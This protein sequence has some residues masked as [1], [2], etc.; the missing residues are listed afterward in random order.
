[1]RRRNNIPTPH[2]LWAIRKFEQMIHTYVEE[3][4]LNMAKGTGHA[5]STAYFERHHRSDGA[6][7][8]VYSRFD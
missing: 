4:C 7:E 2:G 8:E 5:G 6:R 1:M 3:K